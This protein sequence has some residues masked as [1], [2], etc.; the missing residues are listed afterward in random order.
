MKNS[1]LTAC[2]LT[3]GLTLSACAVQSETFAPTHL[4]N[5]V[6]VAESI[7]RLEL[8]TR[9]NGMELS[10]RDKL[11]VAQFLDGYARS[12]D[13]ALYINRPA[14]AMAGLGTQQAE[15]VIRGLMAQGGMNPQAVQTGQ[16][17]SRPG[18]PAPVIVS[19]RTLRAIPQDCREMGS[20]TNTYSNQPHGNFGCF[21][22]ANLAAMISDPRQLLEPYAPGQPN[23]QRRQAIYDKYIQ[24]EPTAAQVSPDQQVGASN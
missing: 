19:Y 1:I 16:Y 22:A 17:A 5:A 20:L 7:E 13:G 4:R 12:G 2:V 23:A 15:A 11:A 21:Q 18:A 10:A 3:I 24:G 9:P 14:T 8:Y 6:N